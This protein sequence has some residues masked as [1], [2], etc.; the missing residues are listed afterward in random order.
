MDETGL[1]IN[2][3]CPV[4]FDEIPCFTANERFMQHVGIHSDS[5]ML[6]I[7]TIK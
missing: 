7:S 3:Y 4:I 2:Y 6:I 1:I 5:F